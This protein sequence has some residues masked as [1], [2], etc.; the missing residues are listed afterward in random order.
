MSEERVSRTSGAF[1]QAVLPARQRFVGR[2]LRPLRDPNPILQKELQATFRTALFIRFLYLSIGLIGLFVVSVGAVVGADDTL[3][4]EIGSVLF[5][6]FFTPVGLVITLVAP[7][8]A[9]GTISGEK[10]SGTFESL[11]LSGMSASRI[12]RGKF[13]ATY[14]SIALWVV[15]VAPVVGLSFLFGGVSPLAVLSGFL[16]LFLSLAPAVA[17]GIALS[18]RVDSMW[19]AILLA[20]SVYGLGWLF[21]GGPIVIGLGELAHEAWGTPQGPFW[22]AEAFAVRAGEW[23][24]WLYLVAL[25]L[26]LFGMPTWFFL[27][28]AV[29]G[30][31]PPAEDRV[32][33]FKIWSVPAIVGASVLG[34]LVQLRAG[35]PTELGEVGAILSTLISGTLALFI[36]LLF[37]NEP[38]LPPRLGKP[39]LLR[40]LLAPLG[41]GAAGTLRFGLLAVGAAAVLPPL[42]TAALRWALYPSLAPGHHLLYDAGLAVLAV[43]NAAIAAHFAALTTWLRLVL[44]SGLAARMLT[45]A[46]FGAACLA[47][48]LVSM[49]LDPNSLDR[50]D[51]TAPPLPMLLSPLLPTIVALVGAHGAPPS[52]AWMVAVPVAGYGGLALVLW[53]AVELR[54]RTAR[55]LAAERRERLLARTAAAPAPEAAPSAPPAG[56]EEIP[57]ARAEGEP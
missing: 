47:P 34:L 4:A 22:F 25:P 33:P 57:P 26:Y 39:S 19:V 50:L 7:A 37:A 14:G 35:S 29:A 10:R 36:A 21:F 53:I 28:S 51:V 31:Q 55:R 20:F 18:A 13:L 30:V 40:T 24:A 43:G 16:W 52:W 56:G 38:P 23:D 32:T 11:L 27:T 46:F 9:A 15:A 3:P 41:P 6:V 1:G 48:L 12:V 45:L 17:F 5:H 49:L 2:L 42:S 8:Y 54:C 44:R